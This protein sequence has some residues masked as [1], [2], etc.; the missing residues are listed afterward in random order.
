MTI[1][2][3]VVSAL[4]R[5]AQGRGAISGEIRKHRQDDNQRQ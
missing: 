2:G 4:M 1:H 5:F 3:G